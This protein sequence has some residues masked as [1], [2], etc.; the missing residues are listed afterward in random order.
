MIDKNE[1]IFL[2]DFEYSGNN[3]RGIEFGNLFNEL[4]SK[5]APIFEIDENMIPNLELR[6]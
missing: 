3:F 1:A 2:I 4:A 6:S 5:Y